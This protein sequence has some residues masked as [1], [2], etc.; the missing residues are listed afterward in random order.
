MANRRTSLRSEE[1]AELKRLYKDLE[2]AIRKVNLVLRK[3]GMASEAFI[4][5]DHEV[6]R[7]FQ[8]IKKIHSPIGPLKVRPKRHWAWNDGSYS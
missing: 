7:I 1:G 5:A 8:R 3:S 4:N 2:S 6:T